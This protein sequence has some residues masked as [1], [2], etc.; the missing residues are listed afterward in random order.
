MKDNYIH[1]QE[2]WDEAKCE[3][4]LKHKYKDGCGTKHHRGGLIS[5]SGSAYPQ[6]GQTKR[7]NGGCIREDE[8]YQSETIPL[9]KVPIG[10]GFEY[11]STWGTYLVRL[12]PNI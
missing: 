11:V 4:V 2:I 3:K 5:H 10:W 7:Y 8:H 6:Y 1:P 12:D 9:P